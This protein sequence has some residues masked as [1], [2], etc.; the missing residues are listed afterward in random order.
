MG[1]EAKRDDKLMKDNFLIALAGQQ[2]AGK[3][4]TYNMLTGASQHVA[5]YPG[6]TVDKKVG[7][8]REGKTRYEVVDLPGTYS[9]TSFSL[10]ERVSREFLLEEKP[11][12]VVNVMD[13]TCLRRSLY[14][15]FQVLEMNFP[16]TVA[17]NMM[18]VAHNQGISINLQEL[19]SRL[20]IDV[21]ATVGRKGKG[22]QALKAAIR[23]SV[24][25]ESYSSP[26]AVD[27]K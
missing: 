19:S 10:E 15:T 20:G 1:A 24:N 11:D 2:N 27:Y 14:F 4:T 26:V 23:K 6:V 7:S 18:D 17:L 13:A 22:K 8:Y 12:V 25:Q 5:N 9:L 21:V 16:V 3:S